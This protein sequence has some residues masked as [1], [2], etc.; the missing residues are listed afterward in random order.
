MTPTSL[1]HHPPPDRWT[2]ADYLKYPKILSQIVWPNKCRSQ[3]PSSPWDRQQRLKLIW[4]LLSKALLGIRSGATM[5]VVLMVAQN[6][7]ASIPVAVIQSDISHGACRAYGL[8][9]LLPTHKG[10]FWISQDV[11]GKQLKCSTRHVRNY[12]SEL[13][14]AGFLENTGDYHGQY[15]IYRLLGGSQTEEPT[16]FGNPVPAIKK[17]KLNLFNLGQ[18]SSEVPETQAQSLLEQNPDWAAE[19][20]CFDGKEGRPTLIQKIEE[21]IGRFNYGSLVGYVK[22]YLRNGAKWLLQ[23]LTKIYNLAPEIQPASLE[24]LNRERRDQ[25]AKKRAYNNRYMP[26]EIKQTEEDQN[27]I[28]EAFSKLTTGILNNFVQAND[29]LTTT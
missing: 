14:V 20:Q 13:E 28:R 23:G 16:D 2:F 25:E 26:K 9:S 27:F 17:F 11:L 19:F 6:L 15:R 1:R 5:E 24:D 12:L 3:L 7:N 29:L 21:A 8:M 18:S 22:H 4:A 10:R